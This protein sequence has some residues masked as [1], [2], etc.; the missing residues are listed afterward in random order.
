MEVDGGSNTSSGTST[1]AQGQEKSGTQKRSCQ[2]DPLV[3]LIST[4]F[5]FDFLLKQ[6]E[7][8]SHFM[9]QG[10]NKS[11]VKAKTSA[12]STVKK[13]KE[14]DNRSPT[15]TT[16][17]HP[18]HPRIYR[19]HTEYVWLILSRHRMTEQ[20]EDEELLADLHSAKKNI[21]TFDASPNYIKGGTMRDYQVGLTP[22]GRTVIDFNRFEVWIGW[23]DCTRMGSMAFWLTRWAWVKP[24]KR[25]PC[26][27][28]WSTSA[29]FPDPIWFL[30]LSPP[31][32]TGW[33]NSRNGVQP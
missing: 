29:M 32:P 4:C 2:P 3:F 8:F 27:D 19:E 30:F 21:I 24:S 33:T 11:P 9:G 6:T 28:T 15:T 12:K 1:P 20:E 26:S 17:A 10:K 31:S 7:L 5:R 25:Y 23:S 18:H 14:G 22:R 16:L 13:G